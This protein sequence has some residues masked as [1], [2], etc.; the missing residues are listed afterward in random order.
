MVV[1]FPLS[2][3]GSNAL[4]NCVLSCHWRIDVPFNLPVPLDN[5]HSR[6]YNVIKALC[7]QSAFA[8]QKETVSPWRA[9][10]IPRT[11]CSGS[12]G[13][14]ACHTRSDGALE[15]YPTFSGLSGVL[16]GIA[17]IADVSLP[18]RSAYRPKSGCVPGPL[19][20]D[21]GVVILFAIG[22][23]YLLTKRR[24]AQVGKRILSR[25]GKQMALASAP[26]LGTGA[27]LTL[28]FLQHNLLWQIY[29]V[30][31]L[32]YGIAVCAVGLFSQREVTNVGRAFLGAGTLN[33]L[34]F[35]DRGLPMMAVT[36]GGFHILYGILMARK[37]RW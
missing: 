10:R 26:G 27:V 7:H 6:A 24:A 13:T 17:S 33:L 35:P 4:V 34:L 18:A 25:L 9:A 8:P 37:D 2:R 20:G 28:Y 32:C 30:W 11:R 22:A 36:F 15:K 19:S 21:L 1:S 3:E 16:A 23:D 31:M 29:P 14:S 12:S 5:P